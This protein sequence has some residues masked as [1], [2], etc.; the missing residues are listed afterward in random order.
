MK[1]LA[2]A[3]AVALLAGTAEVH[4]VFNEMEARAGDFPPPSCA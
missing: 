3:A 1:L 2:F 4:V